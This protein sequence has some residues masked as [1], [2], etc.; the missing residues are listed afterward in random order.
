VLDDSAWAARARAEGL[1]F[2]ASRFGVD[3]MVAETLEI[4]GLPVYASG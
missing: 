2:V 4:Y 3:R 1:A